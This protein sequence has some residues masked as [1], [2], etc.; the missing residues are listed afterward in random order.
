MRN[1]DNKELDYSETAL[2]KC[3]QIPLKI[4]TIL[5]R[6]IKFV[7]ICRLAIGAITED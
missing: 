4:V 2:E 6:Q 3:M 5:L 1:K 7:Q